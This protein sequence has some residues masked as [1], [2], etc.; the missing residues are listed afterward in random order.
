MGSYQLK[1]TSDHQY[2]FNLKASNGQDILTSE[3]YE[4][5]QG[6]EN[7]IN[8]VR[9]NS[10]MDASYDRRMSENMKPY[11]VLK[12]ANG[13]IIGRSQLYSSVEACENGIHSVKDNGPRSP[14]DD[15]T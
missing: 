4:T 3:R 15:Q 14:V 11:F 13:L 7:G 9:V 8:S 2:M 1:R 5:K 10:P 12:A 6:A